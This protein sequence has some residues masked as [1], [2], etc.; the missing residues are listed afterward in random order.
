MYSLSQE[1]FSRASFMSI[2]SI[3]PL[4][5]S[6]TLEYM[7]AWSIWKK[8]PARSFSL[9]TPALNASSNILCGMLVNSPLFVKLPSLKS[10]FF[11]FNASFVTFFL[12]VLVYVF[13]IG[14]TVYFSV[15]QDA[16]IFSIYVIQYFTLMGYD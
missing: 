6:L 11:A 4:K 16:A 12:N 2:S 1:Y 3:F 7:V 9:E 10:F 8:V 15:K 14:E 5:T 13:R